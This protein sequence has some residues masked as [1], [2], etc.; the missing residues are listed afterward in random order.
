MRVSNLHVI[1][2][3]VLFGWALTME[4]DFRELLIIEMLSWTKFRAFYLSVVRI[5]L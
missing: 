1:N 5:A 3:D 2:H 4:R